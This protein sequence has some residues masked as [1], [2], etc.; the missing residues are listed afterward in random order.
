MPTLVASG[1][2]NVHASARLLCLIQAV[3]TKEHRC[4]AYS[5]GEGCSE[6]VSLPSRSRL[7]LRPIDVSFCP[8]FLAPAAARRGV[9]KYMR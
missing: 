5:T 2:L 3:I 6:E 7:L 1:L 9:R 8:S 4:A